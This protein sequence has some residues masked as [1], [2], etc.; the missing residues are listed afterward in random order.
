MIPPTAS[1]APEANPATGEAVT[2]GAF[3]VIPETA[4]EAIFSTAVRASAAAPSRDAS[5]LNPPP[6]S[7]I[8]L[9]GTM[10]NMLNAAPMLT[11]QQRRNAAAIQREYDHF[12]GAFFKMSL[13]RLITAMTILAAKLISIIF[14]NTPSKASS[15]ST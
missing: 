15:Y 10:R 7:D 14:R 8:P 9:F 1:A 3:E 6:T 2:A 12:L 13:A 4:W 5:S 11:G